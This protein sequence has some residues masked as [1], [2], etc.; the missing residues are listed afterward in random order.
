MTNIRAEAGQDQPAIR[1]LVSTAFGGD[2]EARLVDA[3]REQ[4]D[5]LLSLVAEQ[6]GQIVGHVAFSPMAAIGDG[7]AIDAAGL[8]PLAVA[9]AMQNQG[10]GGA[11]VREGLD[12]LRSQ[13]VRLVFLLGE[14]DYYARFGFSAADAA[15]F[16][17]PYAGSHFLA[18]RLDPSFS[19]PQSGRADYAPAFADL[20]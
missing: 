6:N 7:K 18:L 16:T 15:P 13:G 17:S 2:D 1:A 8:A 9:P 3:L 19:L 12:Q 4:G 5:L 14:P 20:G 11:L 10:I